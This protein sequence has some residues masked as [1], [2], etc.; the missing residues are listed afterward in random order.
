LASRKSTHRSQARFIARTLP[1]AVG[2]DYPGFIEPQLATLRDN[3]PPGDK[4]VHEIKFDGYRCQLHVRRGKPA[5]FTR[6]GLNWTSKFA[7]IAA[8]AVDLPANH[9]IIDGEIVVQDENGRTRFGDLQADVAGGRTDRMI[10]YAF[11]L[12]YLDGF[13]IRA[14]PLLDRKRVLAGLLDTAG[15]PLFYSEHFETDGVGLFKQACGLGLEGIISKSKSAPYRSG[16]MGTWL[17][18]KCI[19]RDT[20]TVVGF[21]A[22]PGAVGALYLA[23]KEGKDLIYVGKAG[24]GF[25]HKVAA[26]LRRLL[27]PLVVP[28]AMLSKPIR[29]KDATW[30]KPTTKVEIEYRDITN[31]GHLRHASFK[32]VVTR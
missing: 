31:D 28:K 3:A 10:F 6:S 16:R 5:V 20:F 19:M 30:V 13:D 24:T 32:K 27:N 1:G 18:I 8:A 9:A 12:L 25:T 22:H 23:R 4:W 21:L 2:A 17:K 29:K 11:D 14:A 26:E 7:P 15:R